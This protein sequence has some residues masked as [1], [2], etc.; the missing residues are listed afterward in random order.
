MAAGRASGFTTAL[1]DIDTTPQEYLKAIREEFNASYVYVRFS[2]TL[3]VAAGDPVCY[4]VTDTTFSTVDGT[5][6]VNGAGIAMVAHPIGSVS[7]G[8][9]QVLGLSGSITTLTSGAAGN[10]VTN[11]GAANAALK[12]VAA[13]TDQVV[14]SVANVAARTILLSYPL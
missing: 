13:V 14:G 12:I 6:S 7:Y 2:G 10:Q 9:I 8:W 11:T 3:A 4:V 5:N 1:T